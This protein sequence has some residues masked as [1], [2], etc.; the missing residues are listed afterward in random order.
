MSSH[1]DEIHKSE[2][3]LASL[4]WPRSSVPPLAASWARSTRG[5]VS[6]TFTTTLSAPL[7]SL[8]KIWSN[9]LYFYYSTTTTTICIF[10]SVLQIASEPRFPYWVPPSERPISHSQRVSFKLMA[11]SGSQV[12]ANRSRAKIIIKEVL[13]K[14][15]LPWELII[16]NFI[17]IL[18]NT[19][20]ACS[21]LSHRV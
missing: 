16:S 17:K 2:E 13:L 11:P 15:A 10:A 4:T 9:S 3:P 20:H 21:Y 7:R 5:G 8:P 19:Y 14:G 1:L 12:A 6:L 18:H